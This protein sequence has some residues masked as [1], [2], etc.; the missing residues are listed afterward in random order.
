M[1]GG[2][3]DQKAD[4]IRLL[5][6]VHLIRKDST[7]VYCFHGDKD[8][9]LSVEN[10]RRLFA[11][12]KEVGADIQYTEVKDGSHGFGTKG[13]PSIDEIVAKASDFVIDRLTK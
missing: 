11:R 7:P 13:T 8:T 4:V 2:P 9:V 6:P 3:V 12:G 1:F 5:S 10:S